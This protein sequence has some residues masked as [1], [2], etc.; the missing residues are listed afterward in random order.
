MILAQV[1]LYPIEAEDADQVINASLEELNQS[2]TMHFS[3]G[4]VNT[5]IQGEADEVFRALQRLFERACRDG[6]GEVSM[7][8]TITNARC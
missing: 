5:E 3:V 8:A 6:G 1:A 2:D 4:P 7:V